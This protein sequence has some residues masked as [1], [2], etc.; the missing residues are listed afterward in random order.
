MAHSV[1]ITS[2][3]R[4]RDHRRPSQG[5]TADRAGKAMKLILILLAI[6]IVLGLLLLTAGLLKSAGMASRAEEERMRRRDK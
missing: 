3:L 2:F 6:G 4:R 5:G 1:F